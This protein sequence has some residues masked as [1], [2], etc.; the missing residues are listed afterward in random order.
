MD[1]ALAVD[2]E[3]RWHGQAPRGIAVGDGKVIA[4]AEINLSQV[5]GQRKGK[6]QRVG[7]PELLV[8]QEG[9]VSLW[10]AAMVAIRAGTS[11]EITTSDAPSA[12]ISE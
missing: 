11:G 6:V 1:D 4:E 5:V 8:P 7:H 10:R 2:D 9:E 3:P 12:W